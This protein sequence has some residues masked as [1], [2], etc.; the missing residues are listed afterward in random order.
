MDLE[1]FTR[2]WRSGDGGAELQGAALMTMIQDQA[3]TLRQRV[4]RRLKREASVYLALSVGSGVIMIDRTTAVQLTALGV[5]VVLV[6]TLVLALW[7]G[8]RG[9]AHAAVDQSVRDALHELRVRI[10]RAGRAYLYAYVGVVAGA[11]ALL[12]GVIFARHGG[13]LGFASVLVAGVAG[14]AWAYASGRRYVDRMFR[15]Y[16]AELTRCL[17]QLE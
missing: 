5:V 11:M 15:H 7:L 9:I 14:T 1:T 10:D 4:Q 16:R 6:G 2:D 12:S 17:S 13:G 8:E 3:T